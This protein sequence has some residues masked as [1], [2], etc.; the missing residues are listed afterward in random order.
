[1]NKIGDW[2]DSLFSNK[3]A[4]SVKP[5]NVCAAACF[6]DLS[7]KVYQSDLDVTHVKDRMTQL[8]TN[9][10]RI[11]SS[12]ISLL[13]PSDTT[14]DSASSSDLCSGHQCFVDLQR[15][16]TTH[17]GFAYALDVLTT[18]GTTRDT[19]L[20]NLSDTV[21]GMVS[22]VT[23]GSSANAAVHT[24]TQTVNSLQNDLNRTD[25][26]LSALTMSVNLGSGTT[27]GGTTGTGATTGTTTSSVGDLS[28]LILTV[29]T[30][31]QTVND[32]ESRLNAT[33]GA[34]TQNLMQTARWQPVA[35]AAG[36][37][38]S[39]DKLNDGSKRCD[40]VGDCHTVMASACP[41]HTLAAPYNMDDIGNQQGQCGCFKM[42]DRTTIVS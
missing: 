24:L 10:T 1:M 21:N 40:I 2:F 26:E 3:E 4:S 11:D 23:A 41:A 32:L 17:D 36:L 38:C 15:K 20:Q 39:T 25:A 7:S 5:V 19:T 8:E 29:N 37:I 31:S 16:V 22:S 13:A 18:E 34:T 28:S 6:T 33:N 27:S 42:T 14:A 30:L 35:I 9:V 12:V